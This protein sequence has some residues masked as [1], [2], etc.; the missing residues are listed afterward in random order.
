MKT[1]YKANNRGNGFL[2][3]F[4]PWFETKQNKRG[5]DEKTVSLNLSLLNQ[6][7]GN[8]DTAKFDVNNK[9]GVKF[10]LSEICSILYVIETGKDWKSMHIFEDNK[11]LI[12]VAISSYQRGEETV[13]AL[14]LS[15]VRG[16]GKYRMSLSRGEVVEL[17]SYLQAI[18]NKFHTSLFTAPNF[19]QNAPK[20]QTKPSEPDLPDHDS[21]LTDK[22]S[23]TFDKQAENSYNEYNND[24]VDEDPFNWAN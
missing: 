10:N 2:A 7:G 9:L 18:V 22:L 20:T 8:V 14:S 11:T 19:K 4:K 16:E 12:Q 13:K 15:F 23:Q 3:Q 24:Q 5:H 17:R 6:I 21:E 1:F